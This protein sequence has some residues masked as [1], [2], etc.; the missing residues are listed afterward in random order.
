MLNNHNMAEK[1]SFEKLKAKKTKNLKL[2]RNQGL[3]NNFKANK[4]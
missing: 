3:Y 1:K 2:W 4:Q